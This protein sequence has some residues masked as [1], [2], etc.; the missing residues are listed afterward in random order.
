MR[1]GPLVVSIS[2]LRRCHWRSSI[3]PMSSRRA[4]IGESY[5][6][7]GP[8]PEGPALS[9]GLLPLV[10]VGHLEVGVVVV[11]DRFLV[12]QHDLLALFRRLLN[13]ERDLES[14]HAPVA[15][16]EHRLAVH[17]RLVELLKLP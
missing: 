11:R 12:R 15:V 6:L 5:L 10:Q 8:P 4:Y 17:D 13:G 2:P 9:P 16:V 3:K 14:A 1:A 7:Q